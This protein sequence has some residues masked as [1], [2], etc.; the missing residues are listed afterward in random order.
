MLRFF[1]I[2]L[3]T[4]FL[5]GAVLDL[6]NCALWGIR[7]TPVPAPVASLPPTRYEMDPT[8]LLTAVRQLI[9]ELLCE[10]PEANGLVLSSQMHCVVFTD[11]KGV[12]SSNIITWKDQRA[13]EAHPSGT[14]TYAE[15]LARRVSAEEQQQIGR[16]LRVGVPITTLFWLKEQGL[17]RAGDYSAS[18]PD[19][20][21]ANLCGVEPT[22]E[23]TQAAAQGLFHL[24]NLDWHHALIAKL[25][26]D[27]LR[28]PRVRR[29]G[30]DV[31]VAEV[32]GRQL[33][34]FTPVGDQQCALVGA[35]LEEGELSLN[36][37][38]GSQVSV[39]SRT[40]RDV[41]CQVRP[42]FDGQ[43]LNTIVQVPAGRA[44]ELLVDLLTDIGRPQRTHDLDPWE[45]IEKAVE[46]VETTDLQVNLAFYAGAMGDRGSIANI[47]EG[48]FTVGHLFAAAFRS[49]A[50][51]Y[52]ACA[53]RLSRSEEWRRVVFSGGVAQ[54]FPR[55]RREILKRLG[56][57]VE[58]RLCSVTEDTLCG[59]LTL[60]LVCSGRAATVA[61]ASRL[62][63]DAALS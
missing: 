9:G 15:V 52:V 3:G 62:V 55:L 63:G 4:S 29:F 16:E 33:A 44:L 38:T 59:L 28:W 13:L 14:G 35:A 54:R 2:D 37:S 22:T 58:H 19:F 30:E 1:G 5:K 24:D 46:Q 48:N 39:L 25:G 45:N 61:E 51:N 42:F 26:L 40:R 43:W 47:R 11:A 41:N 27:G 23:A 53:R 49:M 32:A 34:C 18:L 31:G 7:R 60:A 6:E 20:L 56:G 36:I 50:V 57:N 21:L 10:E 8:D 12:P 17:L